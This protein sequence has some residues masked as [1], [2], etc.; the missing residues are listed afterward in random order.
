MISVEKEDMWGERFM[1]RTPLLIKVPVF[2]M[3]D[4]R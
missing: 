2:T 3:L 1:K 4:P